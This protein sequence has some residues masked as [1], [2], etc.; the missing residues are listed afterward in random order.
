MA[1]ATKDP[2]RYRPAAD[3]PHGGPVAPAEMRPSA[4]LLAELAGRGEGGS[5]A[6]T[7]DLRTLAVW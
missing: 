7:G 3:S 6:T 1:L 4:G 2:Y 5:P